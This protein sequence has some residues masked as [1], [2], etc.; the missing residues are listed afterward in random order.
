MNMGLITGLFNT[1][2]I[3]DYD[4]D[5]DLDMYLQ[6]HSVHSSRSYGNA[7]IAFLKHDSLSG[8]RLFRNDIENGKHVFS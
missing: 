3:F 4:M 6:N 8:G 2:S 7:F 5:G 1:G